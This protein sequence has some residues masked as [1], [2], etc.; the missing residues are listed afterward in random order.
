MTTPVRSW[1]HVRTVGT[2][3]AVGVGRAGAVLAC[4]VV[5]GLVG[6]FVMAA[7]LGFDLLG[8]RCPSAA[9]SPGFSLFGGGGCGN[10]VSFLLL[11]P[12]FVVGAGV[13]AV[14]GVG[15]IR[16]GR[17]VRTRVCTAGRQHRSG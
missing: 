5:F 7:L 16:V 6:E 2:R 4:A 14:F 10:S 13:G 8:H 9:S 3:H 11:S 15:V 17:V 12:G 1:D